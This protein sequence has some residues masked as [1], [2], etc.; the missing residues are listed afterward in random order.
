L[1]LHYLKGLTVSPRLL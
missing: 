1:P